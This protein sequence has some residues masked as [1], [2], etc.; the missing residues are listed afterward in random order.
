MTLCKAVSCYN[1]RLPTLPKP[2]FFTSIITFGVANIFSQERLWCAYHSKCLNKFFNNFEFVGGLIFEFC[3]M[4]T[5]ETWFNGNCG[6]LIIKN[7]LAFPEY[8]YCVWIVVYEPKRGER[9]ETVVVVK[10]STNYGSLSGAMDKA[11]ELKNKLQDDSWESNPI[12]YLYDC[13]NVYKFFSN[14]VTDPYVIRI[15][16]PHS[17]SVEN[18]LRPLDVVWAKRRGGF[19][20]PYYHV[21]IYLGKGNEGKSRMC[22]LNDNEGVKI[23]DW[24]IF[25][26]TSSCEKLIGYH[27]VIPFKHYKKIAKQI[28]ATVDANWRN[29]N[30]SLLSRNCEHFANMIV[31]GIN[32]S[33]QVSGLQHAWN[34]ETINLTNE[35]SESNSKLGWKTNDWSRWIKY[36]ARQEV[37]PKEHCRI[38]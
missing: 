15:D 32:H 22:H 24:E 20:V 21:G 10:Y 31:Y 4:E 27:P 19:G 8:P 28:A 13:A 6:Y 37:P 1:E 14:I 7:S 30:Y 5:F 38:M 16:L 11:Q 33:E 36:Q 23:T 34:D 18:Y 29:G 2:D 26:G 25:L 17:H 9:D 12:L 3:E 35:I